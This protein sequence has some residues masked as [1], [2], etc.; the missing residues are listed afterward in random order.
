MQKKLVIKQ[1]DA[2]DCGVCSLLS[3]IKFYGGYVPI[4]KLRM[5][6]YTNNEGTSFYHLIRA[7]MKYGFEATGMKLDFE[8]LTLGKIRL[9]IIVHLQLKNNFLHF[10]VLYKITKNT[11][12]LMDPAKGMLKM[13]KSEFL[14]IWTK[15]AIIIN[16]IQNIVSIPKDKKLYTLFLELLPFERNLI[17]KM[18]ITSIA[19]TVF[20]IITGFYFKVS[21]SNIDNQSNLFIPVSI[22]FALMILMKIL[23]KYIRNHF[24][25]FLNKNLDIRIIPPFIKHVFLL[26][27]TIVKSRQTGEIATRV[28]D[29]NSIKNLFSQIFVS[30]CL[31][32][33]LAGGA[34]FVLFKVN[35][36]LFFILCLI[37]VIYALSGW[38]FGPLIYKRI[39]AN[40]ES[41]TEF[42]S[43]L[44]ENIDG[45]LAIK[46]TNKVDYVLKKL[47]K[48]FVEYLKDSF[49]LSNLLNIQN[50]IKEFIN[51]IGLFLINAYGL[52][53][54]LNNRLSI[55]DLITFNTILVYLFDPIK[56]MVD[57]I[58]G[59]NHLKAT[60]TK[61][62]EFSNLKTENTEKGTENFI[63]GSIKMENLS[64][65]YN[66]YDYLLKN[67]SLE[68]KKGSN[69]FIKGASGC[70][71]STICRLLYRLMDNK[72]G[73]I[74]VG[75]I[76]IKDYKI[77]TI[78]ENI[79][80]LA[81]KEN[82]F[83]DTVRNNI[84]MGRPISTDELQKIIE[85][86]R[87]NE[88]IDTKPLRL[89]TIML[90]GGFNFSGGEKQRIALVRALV[91][92]SKILILDEALSEVPEYLERQ[93]IKDIKREYKDKTIIYI[94]HRSN[95]KLFDKVINL[96]NANA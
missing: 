91:K 31:D 61:V 9:P 26:P 30:I 90:D 48:N 94:S 80:Y 83:S 6:T 35:T 1:R 5:D 66:D 22:I 44:I 81:Q 39:M 3:V 92:R 32:L 89:E 33:L 84:V 4:E 75:G 70:G 60:L 37:A 45:I 67:V 21:L 16:P 49:K 96:E 10:A 52:Y 74:T 68:I 24:E 17:I 77:R 76:N 56:A 27:L 43:H 36:N 63:D 65:S 34:M 72:E 58:P 55:V 95:E 19:F 85:I 88:I 93:I 12:V 78:R 7:S 38:F 46:N 69:V 28:S 86:T 42:N 11:V 15:R 53:L 41:E 82:L 79:T 29:L 73:K 57:M 2:R 54:I 62:S 25:I 64:F 20:A 50:I 59:I 47:E 51:E 18:I 87:V 71:K 14:S 40:I 13:K 8:N 23:L